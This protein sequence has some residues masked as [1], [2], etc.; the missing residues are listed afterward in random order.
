MIFEIENFLGYPK[1]MDQTGY[2]VVATGH[3]PHKFPFEYQVP[4]PFY[5]ALCLKTQEVLLRLQPKY[6]I[7]GGAVGYDT[8]FAKVAYKN[9]IPY[10]IYQ[11]FPEQDCKWPKPARETY[12]KMLKFAEKVVVCNSGPYHP[13]LMIERDKQMVDQLKDSNDYLLACWNNSSGGTAHTV[14]YAI[15]NNKNIIRIDPNNIKY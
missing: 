12:A 3:R 1:D 6:V 11:P 5:N 7:S 8:L 2:I 10:H 13:S 15:E 9:K 4:N 14:N